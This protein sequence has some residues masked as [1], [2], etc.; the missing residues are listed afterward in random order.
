MTP[1]PGLRVNTSNQPCTPSTSNTDQ[2]QSQGKECKEKP[3]FILSLLPIIS[4]KGFLVF[5]LV[6]VPTANTTC[7]PSLYG[8]LEASSEQPEGDDVFFDMLVKCQVKKI[9]CIT[10]CLVH[11]LKV[12]HVIT[13]RFWVHEFRSQEVALII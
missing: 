2:V 5:F 8:R 10:S 6:P 3:T 9:H 11:A 13:L 1:F 12:F 7:T 4:R